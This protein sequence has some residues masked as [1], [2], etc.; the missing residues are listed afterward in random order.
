[1]AI[2]IDYIGCPNNHTAADFYPPVRD[3]VIVDVLPEEIDTHESA[4]PRQGLFRNLHCLHRSW[5]GSFI[6]ND[7]GRNER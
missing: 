6:G 1:M 3:G 2:P 4:T 7:L 5:N